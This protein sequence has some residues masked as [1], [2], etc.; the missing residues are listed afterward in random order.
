MLDGYVNDQVANYDMDETVCA[1]PLTTCTPGA[2]WLDCSG[3]NSSFCLWMRRV[4]ITG[5]DLRC[6]GGL[7]VKGHQQASV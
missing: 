3:S 7:A 5:T 4:N 1:T 2:G 6:D